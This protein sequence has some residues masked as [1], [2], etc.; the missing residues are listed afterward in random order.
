MRKIAQLL[1][2]IFFATYAVAQQ[3]ELTSKQMGK[4]MKKEAYRTNPDY[5]CFIPGSYDY[6]TGDSHNEHF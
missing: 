3:N 5:L 1:V 6:R 2:C 4:F